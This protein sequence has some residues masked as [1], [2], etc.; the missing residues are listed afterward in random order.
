MDDLPFTLPVRSALAQF[1]VLNDEEKRQFYWALQN[2]TR[3]R[4]ETLES[5]PAA[6]PWQVFTLADAYQERPPVEYVAGRL[7]ALPS[8]NILYG[9]PGTLKSFLLADLAVC[10]AGGLEW[11]PPAPW[12][13]GSR[14]GSAGRGIP[15]RQRPVMWL[16]FDNGRRRTHDRF[17]ALGRARDLPADVPLYYYS[18]PSPWLDASDKASV[19]ALAARIREFGVRLVMID[20]LGVISG[21]AEENSGDMARVMSEFRQLAEETEAAIVL[22][23]HQRKSNGSLGR[24]GDT[25]RGHSSIEASLDL[26]LLVDR[27]DLADTVTLRATKVRGADVLPFSAV[28]T[29]ENRADGELYKARFYGIAADD[30]RSGGAIEREIFAALAGAAMNKTDLAKRVKE[31]LPEVGINRIRDYIDRLA[32]SQRLKV[33]SGRNNTER[34]YQLGD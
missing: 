20:N 28:F 15:T 2:P 31:A 34:I 1:Q 29:Y 3:A 7:F 26:A 19:G 33:A 14:G 9:A 12:L 13:N 11:L 24:A 27:E 8:L 23:H 21:D 16:D 17:G 22:V 32:A 25:L 6:D 4:Q 10:V 5:A 30:T 18:M